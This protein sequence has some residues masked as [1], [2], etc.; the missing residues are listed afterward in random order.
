MK[1]PPQPPYRQ[2]LDALWLPL[3]G[4]W[5]KTVNLHREGDGR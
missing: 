3:S 5:A 2:E 1:R 4:F